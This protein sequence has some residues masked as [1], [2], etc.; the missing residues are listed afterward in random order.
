MLCRPGKQAK[1]YRL[2]ASRHFL[3]RYSWRPLS[4]SIKHG[5]AC[6]NAQ[7]AGTYAL[8]GK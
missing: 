8:I 5:V 6:A 7:V 3:L 2:E 4:T 1:I